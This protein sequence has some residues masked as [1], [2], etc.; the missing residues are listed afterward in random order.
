MA[1]SISGLPETGPLRNHGFAINPSCRE[2]IRRFEGS[3]KA[4]K[5]YMQLKTGGMD[6][7]SRAGN[8]WLMETAGEEAC[9]ELG[10]Y[11]DRKGILSCL[12]WHGRGLSLE[13]S[14]RKVLV[15]QEVSAN[16]R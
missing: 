13:D 10:R 16:C 3:A 2:A 5:D 7:W 8:D 6:G 14:V 4:F 11:L 12:R 9:R 15:D 1:V